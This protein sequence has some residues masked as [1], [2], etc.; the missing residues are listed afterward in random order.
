MPFSLPTPSASIIRSC[1]SFTP[2]TACCYS[3]GPFHRH[4][5]AAPRPEP[6]S[7]PPCFHG[8]PFSTDSLLICTSGHISP[9]NPPNGVPF[10]WSKILLQTACYDPQGLMQ[11]G[12][13]CLCLLIFWMRQVPATLV[14]S[15]PHPLFLSVLSAQNSFLSTFFP[16]GSSD[17]SSSEMA[18]HSPIGEAPCF[19]FFMALKFS[20]LFLC[21]VFAVCAP[22]W[23]SRSLRAG[24]LSCSLLERGA[25]D[26][27]VC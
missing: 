21:S 16:P 7:W 9:Q 10:T 4:C 13:D 22:R 15:V 5:S 23:R 1:L 27:G 14:F 8:H 25:R 11:W 20:Y 24:T 19:L 2:F 6:S 26:R 3:P 18:A 12:P 17:G